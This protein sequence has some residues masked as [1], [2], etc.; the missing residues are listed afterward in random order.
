MD[1]KTQERFNEFFAEWLREQRSFDDVTQV[2]SVRQVTNSS[3]YCESCWS[4]WE[5]VQITFV[6]EDGT[7][8]RYDYYGSIADFFDVKSY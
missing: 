7:E 2:T 3:G 5:E 1:S 8:D 6:R 4:E